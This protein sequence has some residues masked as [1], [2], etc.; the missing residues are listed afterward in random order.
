MKRFN[1]KTIKQILLVLLTMLSV[2][3]SYAYACF[4][5]YPKNTNDYNGLH[6]LDYGFEGEEKNTLSYFAAGNSNLQHGLNPLVIYKDQNIAGYN[7]GLG[8]QNIES[9]FK[10]FKRSC[11]DQKYKLLI[12]ETDMLYQME[13]YS[14]YIYKE[15]GFT[16]FLK[17]PYY[18]KGKQLKITDFFTPISNGRYFTY[19][20]GYGYLIS[21]LQNSS[22]SPI[23]EDN[24]ISFEKISDKKQKQLDEFVK[25]ATDAGCNVMF[26]TLPFIGSSASCHNLC[27]SIS[28]R[29]KANYLDFNIKSIFEATGFDANEDFAADQHIN[30]KG[31]Y[32]LTKYLGRYINN[33]FDLNK[34]GN[35]NKEKWDESISYYYKLSGVTL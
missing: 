13:K 17:A 12:I 19:L 22:Y 32:K 30:D 6:F 29:Y 9:A 35:Q 10:L 15:D 14:N 16:Y 21:K 31:A 5:F 23:V 1:T 7:N 8:L 25:Y 4:V 27:K 18:N 3:L 2:V 24:N 33:N 34:I 26:M 11:R 28:Q 20:K